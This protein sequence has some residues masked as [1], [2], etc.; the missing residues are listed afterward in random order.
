MLIKALVIELLYFQKVDFVAQIFFI[1][2][3][4]SF[5][6]CTNLEA[7]HLEVIY[8]NEV[9]T[10]TIFRLRAKSTSRNTVRDLSLQV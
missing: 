7:L 6:C 9:S 2:T 3:W 4:Y 1:I 5:V 10:T 8:I